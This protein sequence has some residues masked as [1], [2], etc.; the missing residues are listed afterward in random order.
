[1]RPAG[2]R[3]SR[4]STSGRATRS[5]SR[6]DAAAGCS[7]TAARTR[8]G[9]SSRSTSAS[10][11]GTGGIDVV[12]L[13]HPHEDHVAGLALLLE[14]YRVGRVFEPGMLGPGPGYAAWHAELRD[15]PPRADCSPTG[16]RL[17]L[18]EIACRVLWPDPGPVPLEPPD[19]GT[20]D[21]QR[22]DRPPRRGRRAAIPADG[23]RR[24]GHRPVAARPAACRASTCSRSPTTAA[25]GDDAG[26]RRR[27]PAARSRSRRRGPA[28]RTAIRRSR[29]STGSRRAARA[30]TGP[31]WTARSSSS[32]SADGLDGQRDRGRAPRRRSR[33]RATAVRT[34]YPAR[35]IAFTCAIPIPAGS[36]LG[37]PAAPVERPRAGDPC[38][39]GRL[40]RPTG[41]HRR[42]TIPGRVEAAS[43]L[44]S[45]DPP[46]WFV[47]H[48]RAVAEVAAWL[49]ARIER[50]RDG[51]RSPARRGGRAA[52]RRRQG[53]PGR[54][55]GRAS[56]TATARRP[57]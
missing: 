26:V 27:R 43:L 55:S 35:P 2:R 14:R 28:T 24:G 54:R 47:R 23:R 38:R 44:L 20:G 19:G 56:P 36:P 32:S 30:S 16:D 11:R 50:P 41:Y 46:P 25:D 37:S 7:S 53:S 34:Q 10:R 8:T 15:G 21:Q 49:A 5:S 18:D 51:G 45:L 12:I 1:M 33:Q 22:L 3:G 42:M 48:A 17:R 29:R 57:G 40:G 9:C 39:V 13:T 6:R 4:S 52:P 31:T